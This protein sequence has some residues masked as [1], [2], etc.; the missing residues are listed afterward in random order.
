[1]KYNSKMFKVLIHST[2]IT[3][4]GLMTLYLSQKLYCRSKYREVKSKR[5]WIRSFK[6][7]KA[8]EGR[9]C[10]PNQNC[11]KSP[12]KKEIFKTVKYK[13]TI[14]SPVRFQK[15][16]C[17]N[18]GFITISLTSSTIMLAKVIH[19]CYWLPYSTHVY[20]YCASG[21]NVISKFTRVGILILATTR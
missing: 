6:L 12:K 16:I 17:L 10:Y 3:L 11:R 15:W 13:G 7:R 8:A 19:K 9:S 20:S 2:G 4:Y 5:L 21:S 14:V 1:M 18:R